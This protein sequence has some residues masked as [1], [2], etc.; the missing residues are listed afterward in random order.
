MIVSL[1]RG[2][3]A[4][5][6]ALFLLAGATAAHAQGVKIGTLTCDVEGGIGFIIGSSKAMECVFHGNAGKERYSGHINKFGLDIGITGSQVLSWVVFAPGDVQP[7]ALTG[8]YVGATAEATA[9]IGAGANVL[10]GGFNRNIQLQPVS[11]S[12]QTGLNVAAGV[13]ELTL[14]AR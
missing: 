9:A 8:T 10:I 2:A 1:I 7:G 14:Q 12:G 6:G 11:V 5:A 3:A 4:A 13:A